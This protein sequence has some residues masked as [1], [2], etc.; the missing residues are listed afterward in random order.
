MNDTRPNVG[1]RI[2][3]IRQQRGLSLRGLAAQSGLSVNAISLIERNE[4]SPT[5]SSLHMLATALEV[6]ITE[7]FR[8]EYEEETVFILPDQRLQSDGEG[9]RMESL[10]IGLRNQQMEPFLMIVEPGARSTEDP[11]TH[12]GE[13]FVYCL[14]GEIMYTV[15][16]DTFVMEPGSSLLFKSVQPHIFR[17]DTESVAVLM[18]VFV[19]RAGGSNIGRRRHLP[20]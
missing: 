5:V 14:E 13:E 11:L 10:G 20:G 9:I 1:G 6:P 17:N 12:P 8:A 19:S 7:F 16:D 18:I 3:D 4:N 2:R 15:A